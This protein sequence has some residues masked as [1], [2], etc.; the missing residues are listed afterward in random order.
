MAIYALSDLH[1]SLG[2]DKPMDVFGDKWKDHAQ[3]LEQNWNQVVVKDDF[4]LVPGD[5]SWGINLDEALPDFRF[6]ES[7]NGIKIISKGNHDYWWSTRRKFQAFLDANGFATI[8]MLH[9][10]AYRIGE[11][12]VC[13]TR[14]WT[15]PGDPDFRD[16]D[17]KIFSREMERLR[18]S[19]EEGKRLG[20]R[21]IAMLHYPPFDSNHRP[22]DFAALLK[23]YGAEICV[24]GHIHGR[25]EESWRDEVVDGIRYSLVSADFLSFMPMRVAW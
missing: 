7:L 17:R 23:K 14:G 8:S 12:T 1:L 11:Y 19:L 20:G 15:D 13:G 21:I 10:N 24:Y 4:V 2:T 9:N 3:R 16:E 6:I 25:W 22:N 5:I 18:L